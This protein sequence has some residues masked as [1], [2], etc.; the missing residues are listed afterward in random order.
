VSETDGVVEA[1]MPS[2]N[3]VAG[4]R[5]AE[6]SVTARDVLVPVADSRVGMRETPPP[7][8]STVNRPPTDLS[9]LRRAMNRLMTVNGIGRQ[10]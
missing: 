5:T 4:S 1:C 10:V 8:E 6:E 9:G 2:T 7:L 3:K